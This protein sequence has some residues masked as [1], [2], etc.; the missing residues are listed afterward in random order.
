MIVGTA[1]VAAVRM[2]PSASSVRWAGCGED[3]GHRKSAS[4]ASTATVHD[5]ETTRRTRT[6]P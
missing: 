2:D 3:I 4:S 6:M 1:G 5:S